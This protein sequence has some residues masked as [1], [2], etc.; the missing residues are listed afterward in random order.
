MER[1]NMNTLAIFGIPKA[2]IS[3]FMYTGPSLKTHLPTSFRRLCT[4]PV[5]V[6]QGHPSTSTTAALWKLGCTCAWESPYS[7]AFLLLIQM[8]Q[9]CHAVFKT[10]W[11]QRVTKA[12]AD[13]TR[14]QSLWGWRW[15][16]Q[17]FRPNLSPLQQ[18]LSKILLPIQFRKRRGNSQRWARRRLREVCLQ[19]MNAYGT[20]T[21]STNGP[22]EQVPMHTEVEGTACLW[23][24]LSDALKSNWIHP[25]HRFS[26]YLF[27]VPLTQKANFLWQESLPPYFSTLL[28]KSHTDFTMAKGNGQ[29]DPSKSGQDTNR[30]F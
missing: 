21:K 27:L 2:I 9:Q 17:Q 1:D 15:P 7:S 24:T 25:S 8:T 11:G 23:T 19:A 5:E 13:A 28:V 18:C 4:R 26:P 30:P 20:H 22:S 16:W 14:E 12:W 29:W 10:A 3:S 6:A